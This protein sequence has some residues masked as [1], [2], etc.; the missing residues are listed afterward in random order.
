MKQKERK[1]HH[2]W[3]IETPNG[4][5]SLGRCRHCGEVKE[6]YNSFDWLIDARGKRVKMEVEEDDFELALSA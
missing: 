5:K 4:P 3:E 6:F 1:C 2:Y